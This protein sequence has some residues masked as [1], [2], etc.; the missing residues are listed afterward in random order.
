VLFADGWHLVLEL[1]ELALYL[2]VVAL[3][4]KGVA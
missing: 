2:A 4:D 3:I 1:D